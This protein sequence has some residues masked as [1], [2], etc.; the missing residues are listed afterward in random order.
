MIAL[1]TPGK[2]R[3]MVRAEV[4]SI[5]EQIVEQLNRELATSRPKECPGCSSSGVEVYVGCMNYTCG[6]AFGAAGLMR[7]NRCYEAAPVKVAT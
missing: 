2:L 3:R 1:V 7:S 6:T 4:N 5:R